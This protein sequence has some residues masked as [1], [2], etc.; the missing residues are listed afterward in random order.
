MGGGG[1]G[2]PNNHGPLLKYGTL[3]LHVVWGAGYTIITKLSTNGVKKEDVYLKS[4]VTFWC[5]IVKLVVCTIVFLAIEKKEQGK[6]DWQRIKG[7]VF[8][9]N[10]LYMLVPASLYVVQNTLQLEANHRLPPAIYQIASQ[11]KILFAALFTVLLLRRSLNSVKWFALF[12][13][14]SG[15]TLVSFDKASSFEKNEETQFLWGIV[16]V[17]SLSCI[18]GFTGIFLEGILKNS[19]VQPSFWMLSV[20]LA[21]MSILPCTFNVWLKDGRRLEE[22]GW[23][24]WHGWNFW[25]PM[26]AVAL[27]LNGIVSGLCMKYADNILK[28]FAHSMGIIFTLILSFLIFTFAA[29]PAFKI[30][31]SSW[32]F[33]VGT[34]LVMAATYFYSLKNWPCIKA[35]EPTPS[36]VQL[37]TEPSG[38]DGKRASHSMPAG[39]DSFH[40]EVD[41]VTGKTIWTSIGIEEDGPG[42]KQTE[43]HSKKSSKVGTLEEGLL[44]DADRKASRDGGPYQRI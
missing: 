43:A 28:G 9:R 7:E 19:R 26:V 8:N 30:D 11:T 33:W 23:N 1:D 18:S 22:V 34:F 35:E 40:D 10:L 12:I 32:K 17:L 38:G 44:S 6:L 5:E 20:Q 29:A 21:L 2:T 37:R 27:G 3:A 31:L 15:A 24:I 25:T 41:P 14:C 42:D 16:C 4:T 36:P 39:V 13:L